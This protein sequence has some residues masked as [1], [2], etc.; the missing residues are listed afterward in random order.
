MPRRQVQVIAAPARA[1]ASTPSTAFGWSR[2]AIPERLRNEEEDEEEAETD[3]DSGNPKNPSPAQR[4]H[5]YST[6]KRDQVLAA[7]QQQRVYSEA[8]CSFVE[9]KY[10]CNGRAGETL[11]GRNSKALDNARNNEGGVGWRQ[12]TPHRREHEE[13]DR[14]QIHGPLA[15]KDGGR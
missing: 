14:D 12:R 4:L 15:E 8:I 7:E 10:L 13:N 1:A 9:E 11:N 6:N 5:D 3:H 2:C